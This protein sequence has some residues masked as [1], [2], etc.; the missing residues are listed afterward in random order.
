M[1]GIK[2]IGQSG[3]LFI[4]RCDITG[5]MRPGSDASKTLQANGKPIFVNFIF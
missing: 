4:L 3:L 5:F 1:T 2:Q